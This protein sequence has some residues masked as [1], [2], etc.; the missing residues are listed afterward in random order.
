MGSES[1]PGTGS[2][3]KTPLANS[4]GEGS[5]AINGLPTIQTREGAPLVENGGDNE[6]KRTGEIGLT[7]IGDVARGIWHYSRP[8]AL[9]AL[10]IG[11]PIAGNRFESVVTKYSGQESLRVS[12]AITLVSGLISLSAGTLGVTDLVLGGSGVN[13]VRRWIGIAPESR[14]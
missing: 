7:T 10:A 11:A 9:I 3:V 8:F 13:P 14:V 1:V 4:W 2:E 12:M 5:K 6:V